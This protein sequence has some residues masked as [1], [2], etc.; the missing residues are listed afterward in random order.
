MNEPMGI[1]LG[2]D[3]GGSGRGRG[4]FGW[5]ICQ[6]DAGQFHQLDSGVGRYAGEVFDQVTERTERLQLNRSVR[7]A[8]IDAPLFWNRQGELYRNADAIITGAD[9]R[10]PVSINGLY[11][12]VVAQGVLLAALL[13]QHF[14]NLAITEAF[15]GALRDLLNPLPAV[16]Q[17]LPRETGHQQDARTAAYAA[18][19]MHRQAPGWRDL[20]PEEPDPVLPLGTPVS[21]WMPIP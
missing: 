5:S 2:F 17:R 12:A 15:P 18:W 3:P 9:C 20:F 10:N 4:N 7:A 1:F 11:G 13:R 14:V 6:D 16:L 8:G 19:C 21:Y